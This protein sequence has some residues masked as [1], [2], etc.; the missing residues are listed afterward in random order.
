MPLEQPKIVV[1]TKEK[2]EEPRPTLDALWRGVLGSL[3]LDLSEYMYRTWAKKCVP[4]KLTENSLEIACQKK[5]TVDQVKKFESLIQASV[6]EIGKGNYKLIFTVDE[7]LGEKKETPKKPN[8][9]LRKYPY[10]AT[11]HK[12]R[13]SEKIKKRRIL[14]LNLLLTTI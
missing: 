6:N 14:H 13:A 1:K 3:H 8:R 2:K 10:L 12:S 9:N 5:Y 11:Q 4:I 7:S